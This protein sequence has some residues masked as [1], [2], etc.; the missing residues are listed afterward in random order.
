[1]TAPTVPETSSA[2]PLTSTESPSPPVS[3]SE[4]RGEGLG[5]GIATHFAIVL[6]LVAF[7]ASA[8]IVP[9]LLDV[10]TTDDWGYTRSVEILLDEGRLTVLP[11]VAATAVFQILWGALFG[12][13]FGMSLG[14]MRLATVVMVAFGA[15]A[16]YALA[17]DL[18]VARGRAALGTAVYLFN[19]LTFSLAF[20]FMTDPYF[21]SLLIISTAFYVHGLQRSLPADAT[22]IDIDTSPARFRSGHWAILAGSVV[23]GLAFL[24]RQQGALIPVGVALYLLA[25]GQL[26]PVRSW[27]GNLRQIALLLSVGGPTAVM[28]VGYYLWLR[29]SND[30]PTAQENFFR[31]AIDLGWSGA[32]TLFRNLSFIELTYLGLLTLPLVLPAIFGLPRVLRRMRTWGWSLFWLLQAVMLVGVAGYWSQSKF[33]PYIG[34]FFG[35]SGI[36]PPDVLG[37]RPDLIDPEFRRSLTIAAVLG[38]LLLLAILAG[39]VGTAASPLRSRAGLIVAMLAVQVVGILPPSF[40]YINRGYSLDRYL[41][42]LLPLTIILV[43]WALRDRWLFQ[44]LGWLMIA[45]VAVFSVMGTRDFLVYMDSV[46]SYARYANSLGISNQQL[47]AGAAWDGYHL[48]TYGLENGISPRTPNGPWWV[49]FYGAPTDSTFVISSTPRDGYRIVESRTYDAWLR[50]VPQRLF[51]LRR[52]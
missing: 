12:T 25:A 41:L 4:R 18:G 26:W 9:T 21:T 24:T 1:M 30:V 46:W 2:S 23:A 8:F 45:A 39:R 13:V 44:P 6:V 16:L 40:Q 7:A 52:L 33:M 14:V 35:R 3:R 11:A 37:A 29:F 48:Y 22:D 27:R 50:D 10:A 51:L 20:S 15:V 34:Q 47:D 49:Y 32:W 36:G 5:R 38:A 31:S 17:R 42:P 19:P 28:L 43:L